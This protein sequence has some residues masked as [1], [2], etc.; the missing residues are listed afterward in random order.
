[1]TGT[2]DKLRSLFLAFIMVGSVFGATVAFGGTAAAAANSVSLA[3]QEV[4]IS[5]STGSNQATQTVTIDATES[6][7]T[8]TI[9]Y[10][11]AADADV[12]LANGESSVSVTG[13]P[14]SKTGDSTDGDVTV[15]SSGAGTITVDL[16][17]DFTDASN[18]VRLTHVVSDDEGNTFEAPFRLNGDY[19]TEITDG[20]TEYDVFGGETIRLTAGTPNTQIRL[21]EEGDNEFGTQVQNINTAF[22]QSINYDT[23]NLDPGTYRVRFGGENFGATDTLVVNDLGLS[24]SVDGPDT[25]RVNDQIDI[26]ATSG[27]PSDSYTARIVNDDGD[28]VDSR[29]VSGTFDSLGDDEFTIQAPTGDGDYTV[30]LEHDASGVVTSNDITVEPSVSASD[31]TFDSRTFSDERGDVVEIDISIADSGP[32]ATATIDIGQVSE[33][34]YA[35]TTTVEDGDG[36]GDV[37]VLFNSYAAG[38]TNNPDAV[39]NVVSEDD[40]R[41]SLTQAGPF[42]TQIQNA[43]DNPAA[44]TLSSSQYQ[45]LVAPG[46][47]SARTNSNIDETDV[48]TLS[49]SGRSTDSMTTWVAPRGTDVT[50]E[51]IYDNVGDGGNLTQTSVVA[52]GELAVHQIG[53]SGIEGI[54]REQMWTSDDDA[55]QALVDEINAYIGNNFDGTVG[56][57][58]AFLEQENPGPNANPYFVNTQELYGASELIVDAENNTYFLVIDTGE[59]NQNRVGDELRAEF[60][61]KDDSLITDDAD[62]SAADGEFVDDTWTLE[63]ADASLQTNSDGEII[64]RAQAGQTIRGST[65]LAPGTEVTVRVNSQSD[66]SPFVRPLTTTVNSDRTFSVTTDFDDVAP[67]T[68]FTATVRRGGSAISD[69]YDGQL[70]QQPTASVTF[71]DQTVGEADQVVRVASAT[72]SDGGFIAIHEGSA[73]GDVIGVSNQLSDGTHSDVRV[74]L[75]EDVDEGT[76]LVAMPHLD[77]NSNN[78]YDFPSADAPYTSGGAPVTDSGVVSFPA[79]PT[80]TPTPEPTPTPTEEPTPTPTPTPEPTPTPTEEP[81]PTPTEEP[82]PTPTEEPTPTP[83][84]EPTPTPTD[85][86]DSPTPTDEPETTTTSDSGPGFGIVAALIAMLGAALLAARR[87]E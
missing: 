65:N 10:S 28:V 53:M 78:N 1:M 56:S 29:Q 59:L 5:E 47:Q 70:R 27:A 52:E 39:I 55:T 33:D 50:Q 87:N 74:L 18:E 62:D 30:E 38:V 13:G 69:T 23:S 4:D 20:N 73:S 80:P 51:F 45:L 11:D 32:G 82:T 19:T 42:T 21:Y 16:T 63:E 60:N 8:Y 68:N 54:L 79:T 83:T 40:S 77:D 72:L 25:I 3:P 57:F 64:L 31:V 43:G 66:D 41:V 76:T 84:E 36:D 71:N 75:D 14:G 22:G 7:D 61:L 85:E 2:S 26:S 15:T 6:G 12:A 24:F 49:L 58:D 48:A 46:D 9:D 34:N 81:T 44:G 17:W 37:T 67:N 86:P 35:L